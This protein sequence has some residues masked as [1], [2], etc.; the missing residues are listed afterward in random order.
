MKDL[1]FKKKKS[2]LKRKWEE[3]ILIWGEGIVGEDLKDA[4]LLLTE[5]LRD[6][7]VQHDLKES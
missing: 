5:S 6:C 2:G 3:N 4:I 1:L 7:R